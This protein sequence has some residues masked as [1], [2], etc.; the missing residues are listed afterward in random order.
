MLANHQLHLAQKWPR[1][2]V[3]G[4][5]RNRNPVELAQFI[6]ERHSERFFRPIR[7]L[8]K[9]LGNEQG[10]GFAMLA[11]CSLLIETI[12]CYRE[13]LPTT[14]RREFRGLMSLQKV[15]QD[16]RLEEQNWKSSKEVFRRFFHRYQRIFQELPGVR[17]Y[18]HVRCGLLHQGQTKRGWI[19]RCG[20][21]TDWHKQKGEIIINR[22]GFLKALDSCSEKY[23]TELRQGKWTGKTCRHAAKKVWW[24]LRL[25]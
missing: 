16:Y 13:G 21:T 4:I 18:K 8:G 22:D 14:D 2:R 12:Q 3:H 20:G 19:I 17:F 5:L 6:E 7:A 23:L 9:A 24:L 11:L 10:Y 15:P 1:A 25:R